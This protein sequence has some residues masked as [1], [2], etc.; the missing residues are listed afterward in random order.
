MHAQV[1]V[2]QHDMVKMVGSSEQYVSL[3]FQ[4]VLP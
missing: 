4:V 2:K 1:L 3:S